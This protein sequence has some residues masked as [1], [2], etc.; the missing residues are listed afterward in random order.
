MNVLLLI[1]RVVLL[2]VGGGDRSTTKLLEVQCEFTDDYLIGHAMR[3][4][5][6][7][8]QTP[9]ETLERL[10]PTIRNDV[11]HES[12]SIRDAE[13]VNHCRIREIDEPEKNA[14]A[15]ASFLSIPKQAALDIS[16]TDHLF[17]D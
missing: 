10:L 4:G 8:E 15:I 9:M 11:V 5:L 6:A 3:V 1:A 13:L 16:S 14:D 2:L 17:S 7:G 12:D